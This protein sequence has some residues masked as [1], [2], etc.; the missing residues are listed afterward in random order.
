MASDVPAPD[1]SSASEYIR[2]LGRTGGVFGAGLMTTAISGIITI[3]AL[4]RALTPAEYGQLAVLFVFSGL[5]GVAIVY[6]VLPGTMSWSLG[7]ADEDDDGV[8][9]ADR[10]TAADA[11]VSLFT[12]I[13]MM[14][15]LIVV[16]MG[17]VVLLRQPLGQLLVK[18]DAGSDGGVS[19]VLLAALNAVPTAVSRMLGNVLRY[20]HRPVQYVLVDVTRPI[21]AMVFAIVL[22]ATG[23]A[24][25]HTVLVLY[26]VAGGLGL[27]LGVAFMRHD[28]TPRFSLH[29]AVMIL[30]RGRVI[31]PLAVS[32]W[33]VLNGDAFFLAQFAS[34]AAVGTYR[35]ATGIA[36]LG[37]YMAATFIRAWGPM[38]TSPLAAAMRDEL[39]RGRASAATLKYFVLLSCW[40]LVVLAAFSSV[41]VRIA[42]SAYRDAAPLIPALAA[43]YMIRVTF[44]LCYN[45]SQRSSRRRW[46]FSLFGVAAIVFVGSCLL[47]IPPLGSWG[48]AL[49]GDLAYAVPAAVMLTIA[50]R[51]PN[52][53]PLP[54]G[55][56][57]SAIALAAAMIV[58]LGLGGDVPVTVT[59]VI[60]VFAAALYPALLILTGIVPRSLVKPLGSAL[61]A[62]A[63]L[64]RRAPASFRR[65][66]AALSP[67]ELELLDV[68]V[69]RRE[70]LAE[71]ALRAGEREEVVRTHL[72][73]VLRRLSELPPGHPLRAAMSRYVL[74]DE[75]VVHHMSL[76]K[77]LIEDG[78][79]ARALDALYEAAK[80]VRA[81]PRRQ[82]PSGTPSGAGGQRPRRLSTLS[83]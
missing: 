62:V 36:R 23:G 70:D 40:T 82:W 49:A 1:R 46:M 71:L 44:I 50:M 13:V 66:L 76:S 47:L 32:N 75:R 69:R 7:A 67:P 58:L 33:I 42:P 48:A 25:L 22:A 4:T 29:D 37:S 18:G 21:A 16:A 34:P 64:R 15:A 74:E 9:N 31:A 20:A 39:S 80:A 28:V 77:R 79:D 52:P 53:M 78:C 27:L 3:G 10:T 11:R 5:L 55:Q 12:G 26:T 35:V 68:L 72:V 17:L 45:G 54:F 65:R 8:A 56:I 30:R 19:L 57:A 41:L 63:P 43:V 83:S 51:E 61:M 6:V 81:V 24:D 60:G 14:L 73:V 2:R 59:V 38:T